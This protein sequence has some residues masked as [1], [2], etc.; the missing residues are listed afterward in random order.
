VLAIAA[1]SLTAP[2]EACARSHMQT[3]F[4]PMVRTASTAFDMVAT[5]AH[6]DSVLPPARTPTMP[7][8]PLTCTMTT[9]TSIQEHRH[10]HRHRSGRHL[11]RRRPDARQRLYQRIAAD[12]DITL[13]FVTGRGLEAVLPI[14]S[15]PTI[16]VP[17]YVIA[18]VGATVVDGRTRQAVQPLQS[19]DRRRC[20][21]ASCAVTEALSGFESAAAAGS[22]AAAALFL[23][24]RRRRGDRRHPR[25]CQRRIG[26]RRAVFGRPLPRHPAARREQ[27]QH[28]A[29]SWCM[30]LGIDPEQVL[31]AGDTLNDL[32]MFEQG[33]RGVC[34]GESEPALLAAT[35]DRSRILH[36]SRVGCGGII[37]ALRASSASS[38]VSMTAAAPGTGGTMAATP[39]WSSSITGCP[40]RKYIEDGTIVRIGRPSSPN[41]IIPTLLSFFAEGRK[42]SWVAWSTRQRRLARF[43]SAHHGRSPALPQLTCARVA[44]D[45]DDVDIFYKRFS[46]EAFWPTLHTFWE[47]AQFRE[48]H[49]QVFLKVNRLFAERTAAEAAPRRNGVAARLQP[50]D[51]AGQRCANC[52]RT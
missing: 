51:G 38:T 22:A 24:L 20:G 39:N 8:D 15:D 50:V 23:F 27:G 44:L 25:R 9:L 21:R 19:D 31:V 30:L 7:G 47:R 45:K 6:A 41:G 1:S 14:L 29:P 46:K 36:A 2:G 34:V 3:R 32:S 28:A 11:S 10:A 37:D 5:A 17:H 18:D 49:W 43:R 42:G 52:A 4:Q 12:P 33:F 35:A 13:V 26:L 40:T 48:D 16:P